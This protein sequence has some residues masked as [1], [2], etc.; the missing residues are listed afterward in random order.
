MS[1]SLIVP[2]YSELKRQGQQ[3]A[4]AHAVNEARTFI[5]GLSGSSDGQL[6]EDWLQN[7]DNMSSFNQVIF[8]DAYNIASMPGSMS[9]IATSQL[10]MDTITVNQLAMNAIAASSVAMDAV[11][12]SSVAMNAVL[13]NSVAMNAVAASSIAIGKIAVS[14]AGLNPSDY[15]DMTAVAAS[16]V[17][18]DSIAASQAAVDSIV[19]SSVAMDIVSASSRAIAKIVAAVA[20]LDP[21]DYPNMDSIAASQVA[22]D[23]IAASQVAMNS[24]AASQVALLAIFKSE[25]D[26]KIKW[27]I[28]KERGVLD[29]QNNGIH[30]NV[31]NYDVRLDASNN[32]NII[33][34]GSDQFANEA[35]WGFSVDLTGVSSIEIEGSAEG[36]D[37]FISVG[38]TADEIANSSRRVGEHNQQ[39]S[40]SRDAS[41]SIDVSGYSGIQPVFI[42]FRSATSNKPNHTYTR[43]RLV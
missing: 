6:L 22:M 11:A 37:N 14:I 31:G 35:A 36:Y 19:S 39:G 5:L 2:I 34:L 33:Y 29:Y 40:T 3:I 18:M 43:I 30:G 38:M 25:R 32:L 24:I 4:I 9:A 8:S 42:G 41:A 15:P 13:A 7:Q 17:A 23:S 10:A 28:G 1:T 20:G 26:H 27:L 16:S 12:A 21:N